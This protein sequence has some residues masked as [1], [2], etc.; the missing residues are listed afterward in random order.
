MTGVDFK[1]AKPDELQVVQLADLDA[2]VTCDVL[3]CFVQSQIHK[4]HMMDAKKS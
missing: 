1:V 3:G 2:D 4:E